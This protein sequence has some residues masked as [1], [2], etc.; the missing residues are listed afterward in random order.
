M[1]KNHHYGMLYGFLLLAIAAVVSFVE[2]W[3]N[4]L[5][6][7]QNSTHSYQSTAMLW[8][9]ISFE[10]LYVVSL[11]V[12][13]IFVYKDKLAQAAYTAVI[14]VVLTAYTAVGNFSF[15]AGYAI[16][17][18]NAQKEGSLKNQAL[19]TRLSVL[20]GNSTAIVTVDIADKDATKW[21]NQIAKSE[22]KINGCNSKYAGNS[23]WFQQQRDKCKSNAVQLKM[24]AENNLLAY[25]EQ[26]E[27]SKESMK[28]RDNT[29]AELDKVTQEL[30]SENER[31]IA[32][33]F[34]QLLADSPNEQIE[35]QRYLGMM[36]VT[37]VKLI[38]LGC[39]WL[40]ATLLKKETHYAPVSSQENQRQSAQP[41]PV[42]ATN[43]H[44]P[45]WSNGQQSAWG[46]VAQSF[47]QPRAAVPAPA[48]EPVV[49]RGMG[50]R[51]CKAQERLITLIRELGLVQLL[52]T[53]ERIYLK[54][55][56]P[57]QL[58]IREW[59]YPPLLNRVAIPQEV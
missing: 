7:M 57:R 59:I 16:D 50:S 12:A 1:A 55:A 29:I 17:Y 30:S 6:L 2:A 37:I 44:A 46:A 47:M 21:R 3:V 34:V 38:T 58:Q 9:E 24:T 31:F 14:C 35:Y 52:S 45:T 40:G 28:N 15:V 32:L 53:R 20:K 4:I 48:A 27:R 51:M 11:S 25:S 22:A 43:H 39:W 41:R 10:L 5:Q 18:S 26:T 49:E 36:F 8:F 42:Y 13:A 54:K 56:H 23:G 33:P 19:E